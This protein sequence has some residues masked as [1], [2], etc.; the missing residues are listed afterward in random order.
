MPAS[1]ATRL[2]RTLARFIAR[3]LVGAYLRVRVEGLERLPPGPAVLCFS[4]ANWADP[5]IVLAVLPARPTTRFFGPLE[6]DMTRGVRNRLMRWSA[7][8]VPAP[9]GHPLGALRQV[10]AIL[11]GGD[12]IAIAGEGRIHARAREILPLQDGPA[13]LALRTGVP[14]IPI[15]I[16]GTTWLTF[17]GRVLIRI[18]APLAPPG[19]LPSRTAVA[20]LTEQCRAAL[21]ELVAGAP[22]TP[23]PG[24]LGRWLTELFNV[25][26]EGRR[27]PS[28]PG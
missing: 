26:P 21:L 15:A 27:P 19:D 8:A 13:Y 3:L 17:R 25:W 1:L 12:R 28:E 18:G 16:L 9:P 23:P 7:L 10:E 4:H 5:L 24:P 2:R 14:L 11:G 6:A 22:E 20:W